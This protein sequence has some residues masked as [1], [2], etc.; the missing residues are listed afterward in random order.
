[1]RSFICTLIYCTAHS[2]TFD[3]P[4]KARFPNVPASGLGFRVRNLA[5]ELGFRVRNLA[6]E[7]VRF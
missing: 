2:T 4:D 6:L 7:L 3:V 1:M 5:L